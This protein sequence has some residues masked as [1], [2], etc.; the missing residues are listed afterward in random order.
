MRAAILQPTSPVG[1]GLC[2]RKPADVG[3]VVTWITAQ[4]RAG[5]QD[6]KSGMAREQLLMLVIVLWTTT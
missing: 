4:A 6:F 5:V 1:C 3:L 2:W